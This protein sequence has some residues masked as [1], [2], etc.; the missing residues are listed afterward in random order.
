MTEGRRSGAGLA[1]AVLVLVCAHFLARPLLVDWPASPDLLAGGLLLGA[2][3]LRAGHASA[4]GFVLGLVE[5]AAMAS[6][7]GYLAAVYALVAYGAVRSWELFF[8][9]ARLL[10]PLYLLV[11]T[12]V[13]GLG[14]AAVTASALD[15]SYALLQ[16]P[17]SGLLTAV[18]CSPIH[19]LVAAPGS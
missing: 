9:D 2:L 4:L 13:L 14:S 17:A 15:W 7:T 16:A 1:A 18:I 8:A 6:G 11:G 12:W 5:G 3:R 10:V 19:R